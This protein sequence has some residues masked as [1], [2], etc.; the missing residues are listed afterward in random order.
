MDKL[1]FCILLL[2]TYLGAIAI[3]SDAATSKCFRCSTYDAQKTFGPGGILHWLLSEVDG[4]L[5]G[6]FLTTP[7]CLDDFNKM[8][9]DTNYTIDCPSQNCLVSVDLRSGS[10]DLHQCISEVTALE[11]NGHTHYDH[12]EGWTKTRTDFYCYE[13]LCNISGANANSVNIGL[14]I[15]VAFLSSVLVF[16]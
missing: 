1:Y 10:I 6:D 5:E 13:N 8:S 4:H 11:I 3:T 14:S 16:N 15:I 12:Y 2:T 7:K 9:N